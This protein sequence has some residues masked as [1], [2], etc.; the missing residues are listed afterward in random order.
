MPK[1][2]T[3]QPDNKAHAWAAH[4]EAVFLSELQREVAGYIEMVALPGDPAGHVMVVNEEG[5]IRQMSPNPIASWVA[6]QFGYEGILHG[7]VVLARRK[8]EDIIHPSMILVEGLRTA[9]RWKL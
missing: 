9:W 7:P 6:L 2:L 4:T 5:L 8:G 3:I 1:F